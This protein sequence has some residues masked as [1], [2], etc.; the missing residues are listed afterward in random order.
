ME[1]NNQTR[2]FLKAARGE[3]AEAA[4]RLAVET[5]VRLL[6]PVAPHLCEELW[7][8]LGHDESVFRAGW[9]QVDEA[10][11]Q[12]EM[13]ELVLQVGGKFC[14]TVIFPPGASEADVKAAALASD[15]VQGR[16]AG[17]QVVKE[18]FVADKLFNIVVR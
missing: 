7:G 13:L 1:L 11:C 14:G 4:L 6:A 2:T 12:E 17:K 18:V 10:A 5:G 9:P 8:I 15:K 3:G 16:L